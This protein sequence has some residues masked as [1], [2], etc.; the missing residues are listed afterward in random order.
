M[1]AVP[2][3]DCRAIPPC[4]CAQVC[5]AV[6]MLRSHRCLSIAQQAAHLAQTWRAMAVAALQRA[7][8][9]MTAGPKRGGKK[10]KEA[11]M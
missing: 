4:V 6:A 9:A 8:A 5:K 10:Q 2:L 1:F 11:V 7:N 3:T